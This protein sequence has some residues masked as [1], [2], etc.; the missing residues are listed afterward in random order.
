[1]LVN[2]DFALE[3][4]VRKIQIAADSIEDAK[5]RLESMTLEEIFESDS[6]ILDGE[7]V[8]KDISA[9]VEE[10]DI[11]VKVN[12]VTYDLEHGA[13]SEVV[14]YLNTLLDN[15]RTFT[16]YNVSK[17]DDLDSMVCDTLEYR[18]DQDI[19]SVD[20]EIVDEK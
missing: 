7:F 17:E 9:E 2:L 1:M 11:V 13:D 5:R 10:R 3:A 16:I 15:H 4:W 20:Y 19:L 8:I 18:L 12:S 6:L 14:K